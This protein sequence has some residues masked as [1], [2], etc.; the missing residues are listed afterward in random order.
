[1]ELSTTL[2]LIGLFILMEAFFSGSEI[3]M[4]AINRIKMK[5]EAD[6]GSSS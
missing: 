3:G 2:I 6:E 1:M 4:I 5:Q